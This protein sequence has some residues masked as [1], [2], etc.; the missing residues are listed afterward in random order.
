MYSIQQINE[1]VNGQWLQRTDE[2]AIIAHLLLDSRQVLYAKSALFFA[3]PG[4]HHNGHDYLSEVYQQSVRNFIVSQKQSLPFHDANVLLV[5]DSLAALQQ[6]AAHHRQQYH[7]SCIGITGSNGKTIVKELLFQL[8]RHYYRIVRSPKSYNSQ[9][10]VPLSVWQ[11]EPQ[12]DLG[13]FEAGISR[14]GEMEKLT[15][16]IWPQIGVFTNIGPAHSEGFASIEE[17]IAEKIKL[18]DPAHIIAYCK[19]NPLIDKAIGSLSGK[20]FF[21][22]SREGTAD[23]QITSISEKKGVSTLVGL[24]QQNNYKITVPFTDQ[25]YLDNIMHCWAV[26]LLL[27][28]PPESISEAMLHLEPVAM[29]LELK[30]GIN[31]CTLINDSYN[32][33]LGS[34]QIALQFLEQQSQNNPRTLI[35][36][37]IL[38]SRQPADHLYRE[39]ARL[40]AEKKIHRLIGIG[41]NVPITQQYLPEKVMTSFF[42][43]TAGFL[44]TLSPDHFRRETILLKGAR[45]FGFERIANRLSQKVHRTTLE[46]DL[47]ALHHNLQ[48]YTRWLEPGTR[49]MVMVKAAAYGSGG[50]EV[51]RLLEF[52][53]VDYLAVAYIDEGIALRQAG[54]TLPIMVLNPEIDGLDSLLEHHLEP[55]VYHFDLL[56]AII[57]QSSS[58]SFPIH[59]KL[60]TGMHRLGFTPSDIKKLTT[61]LQNN[62]QLQVQS[63]FSHLA[64][65]DDPQHDT[66]TLQQIEHYHQMYAALTR[67]LT[68]RPLCH[69]LNSSGI[70]RFPQHQLDMVRLGIGL[71]GVDTAHQIQDQL[72]VVLTLKATI[73]QIKTI[74]ADQSIGY[75][76]KGVADRERRIAIISI[77]YA[78]GL[79]RM[80]GNGHHRVSI[81]GVLAPTVGNICMDMC[82]VD[83]S[84]IPEA[85]AGDEVIVFGATPSVFDLASSLGT[86]PYEV[87][88]NVSERVRRVYVVE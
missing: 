30:E 25:V 6:L 3:L 44:A 36:S 53:N 74:A 19:D 57:G 4:A 78:D 12:H 31:G 13:I 28:L 72:E 15:P 32:S 79:L 50:V 37:D 63:I 51:A 9:I 45:Q 22:W 1:V 65:S 16:I 35:L 54:I 66:Y 84:Q 70:I 38:Q 82:M 69:L 85:T 86:I 40:I 83:V 14:R 17:K 62:P 33:D 73:S 71:Y 39:V 58:K 75:S 60:D 80:A 21:T 5:D 48:V 10:G 23:L 49:M 88:T 56:E 2:K 87:F 18:F 64:A 77:G 61:I 52:N 43:D 67:A 8:L 29:R 26:L 27:E 7:L 68:Y 47:N 11:I 42:E 81:R 41:N 20:R 46:I 24:F 76:R 34:L 55:E 59:L